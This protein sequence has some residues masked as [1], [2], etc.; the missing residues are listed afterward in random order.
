VV[1][2]FDY[3]GVEFELTSIYFW[4]TERLCGWVQ[5]LRWLVKTGGWLLKDVVCAGEEVGLI[6]WRRGALLVWKKGCMG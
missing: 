4:V 2:E 6:R 3:I 5:R 1:A